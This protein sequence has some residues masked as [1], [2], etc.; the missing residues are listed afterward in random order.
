MR[1]L[2]TGE[3]WQRGDARLVKRAVPGK[4][5]PWGSTG[6]LLEQLR[7]KELVSEGVER[8]KCGPGWGNSRFKGPVVG[9]VG[10]GESSWSIH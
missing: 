4:A 2:D 1:Q 9:W 7:K 3:D 10:K 8:E 5:G 6:Q